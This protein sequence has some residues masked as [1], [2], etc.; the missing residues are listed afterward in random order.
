MIFIYTKETLVGCKTFHH[1][2]KSLEKALFVNNEIDTEDLSHD[3][4]EPVNSSYFK[5]FNCDLL[6]EFELTSAN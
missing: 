1:A 6:H 3:S 5:V 2:S 4:F